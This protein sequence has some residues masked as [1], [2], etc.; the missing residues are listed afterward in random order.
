[1]G[2]TAQ[3]LPF[4][5]PPPTLPLLTLKLMTSHIPPTEPIKYCSY[6]HV[7]NVHHLRLYNLSG[8][9]SLKKTFSPPSAV[10]TVYI[11]SFGNRELWNFFHPCW[12]KDWCCPYS[13]FVNTNILLRFRLCSILVSG[14]HCLIAVIPS[15]LSLTFFQLL[16]WYLLSL[17]CRNCVHDV[18]SGSGQPTVTTFCILS[19]C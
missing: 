16:L 4:S 5:L 1:M 15:P 9:S 8:V 14:K 12:H 6:I 7:F 19:S 17:R 18:L 11:S 10:M 2:H 13:G 3:F